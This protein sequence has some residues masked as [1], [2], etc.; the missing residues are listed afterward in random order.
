VKKEIQDRNIYPVM[1]SDFIAFRIERNEIVTMETNAQFPTFFNDFTTIPYEYDNPDTYIEL[2]YGIEPNYGGFCNNQVAGFIYWCFTDA[3]CEGL[4]ED[5]IPSFPDCIPM[6]FFTVGGLPYWFF[7]NPLAFNDDG[8][9]GFAS[10]IQAC[11]PRADQQTTSGTAAGDWLLRV[12]PYSASATFDYQVM[13]RN[14]TRC[15]FEV[16]PNN[17]F[18]YA[19]PM[20]WGMISGIIDQSNYSPND[21]DHD[22]YSF[23]VE[24][25]S[26]VSFETWGPDAYQSDTGLDLY[27]GPDDY[28]FYYYTGVSNDD[29]YAWLSCMDV[30]LPPANDL[31]GNM[32]VDADYIMDVSTWWLNKNF[33]YTLF[34]SKTVAPTY[35]YE[36][37]PN[38]TCPG[39][40][41]AL[42][43]TILG[44]IGDYYVLGYC[45]YDSYSFT[46]TAN[47]LV[48]IE[49]DGGIDSTI[50]LYGADGYLGCDDDSGYSLGSMLQGCLPPGDYCVQVRTYGYYDTGDYEL[51]ITDGGDCMPTTP[52]YLGETGLRCDGGQAEF[53]TCPN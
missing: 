32:Y 13:V 41:V 3:D 17:D 44:N 19:N 5:P 8:G 21:A 34:S 12:W 11:L 51:A 40:D 52:V 50:A 33:L 10:M 16:E 24:V 29:C 36:V 39:Q 38:D 15:D 46:V 18:P 22:L 23:D 35:T 53:E 47:S 30:I 48:T 28:G 7:E 26:I 2:Y 27:V 6:Q 20:V 1:N 31:L 43:D 25:D 4:L 14:E 37:E 45:D 9:D 49:T 42:G